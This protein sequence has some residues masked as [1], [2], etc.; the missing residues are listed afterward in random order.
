[1]WAA[2][3]CK[4]V[5]IGQTS[6]NGWARMRTHL[7]AL[8]A[9]RDSGKLYDQ[10][11]KMHVSR[12]VFMPV[13]DLSIVA[14]VHAD[15]L[16]IEAQAISLL[17]PS[18]NTR[19]LMPQALQNGPES[20]AVVVIPKRQIQRPVMQLRHAPRSHAS[21]LFRPDM[22]QLAG[23]P[24]R[25][26]SYCDRVN[27][28]ASIARRPLW[29]RRGCCNNNLISL[30]RSWTQPES[31]KML[32]TA[33]RCLNQVSKGILLH[34]FAKVK[35]CFTVVKRCIS[36]PVH[37]DTSFRRCVIRSIRSALT[38]EYS[39]TWHVV[40][41]F[42]TFRPQPSP[43]LLQLCE[44][45]RRHLARP[46]EP[47]ACPCHL[48][49]FRDLP[50]IEGHVCSTLRESIDVLGYCWPSTWNSRSRFAPTSATVCQ[51]LLVQWNSL[52]TKL[53]L[54]HT[55]QL[56][57][58]HTYLIEI[59]LQRCSDTPPV[60]EAEDFRYVLH[61]FVI[62]PVDRAKG[63]LAILCPWKYR[64][65]AETYMSSTSST[66]LTDADVAEFRHDFFVWPNA[67]HCLPYCRFRRGHRHRF[68]SLS[69]HVK[70]KVLFPRVTE[71][72]AM[73]FRPLVSYKQHHWKRLLRI[74][75]QAIDFMQQTIALGFATLSSEV[76]CLKLKSF[77]QDTDPEST[78]RIHIRVDD[79]RD[80]FTRAP[81]AD[82]MECLSWATSELR[83]RTGHYFVRILRRPKQSRT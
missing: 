16:F 27:T 55:A 44:N 20:H 19:G 64:H 63:D 80:F 1:M 30:M 32:G 12:F 8:N 66:K 37:F 26:G 71:W 52:N 62:S 49:Q 10:L 54:R 24:A 5:Y 59:I 74:A 65:C 77:N 42:V 40:V 3:W 60:S 57:A 79:I 68:G 61:D 33:M 36:T 81:R 38:L 48:L 67:L 83:R 39:F 28:I 22:L 23:D 6:T 56:D 21:R 35:G 46:R 15:R 47:A 34:N 31:L 50:K 78:D 69:L 14:P 17:Q 70:A 41:V 29:Q 45:T 13:C 2:P 25:A 73:K 53:K 58:M 11:R 75:C 51:Q 82:V 76:F 7:Y 72:S 43:S 18:L 9:G 4:H